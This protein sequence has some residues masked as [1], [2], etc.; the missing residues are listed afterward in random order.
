M[1][2]YA[3][4]Q[5]ENLNSASGN[6]Q[7]CYIGITADEAVAY[8]EHANGDRD[9]A[10]SERNLTAE[11]ADNGYGIKNN[12]KVLFEGTIDEC[13]DF[14]S[15]NSGWSHSHTPCVWLPVTEA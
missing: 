10:E 15:A 9:G 4:G 3:I 13:R 12:C 11:I 7:S 1:K 8:A 2:V 5:Y 14:C 6:Y